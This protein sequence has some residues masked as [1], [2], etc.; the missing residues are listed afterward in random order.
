MPNPF[1]GVAGAGTLA[2]QSTVQLNSLLVPYP[3][4][5]LNA[6]SMTVPGA[7]SLYNAAVLQLRKRVTGVWGG[8]FSYTYSQLKDNQIGQFGSGNYLAFAAAPGIV[9]NYNYIP[10]SPNYD[11]D[12][13]YGLGLNDMPHKL[14]MAPII[15][16]PFGR[17][18]P[19]ANT[20]WLSH[21]A[22]GWTVAMVG[23]GAERFPDRGHPDAEHHELERRRTAAEPGAW[24]STSWRPATSRNGSGT[25]P[26][27]ICI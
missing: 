11:P 26:P 22:G 1:F 15:Q 18:R 25:T 4:Y 3:Q 16:L 27:T 20:G 12:V 10:G 14:V 21:V 23:D 24:R 2:T 6:V 7:H 17:G 8:N 19:Y 13:D 5:G 9:D